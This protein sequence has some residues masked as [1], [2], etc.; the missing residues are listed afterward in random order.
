[1]VL[2]VV[3]RECLTL[4]FKTFTK[5]HNYFCRAILNV[6]LCVVYMLTKPPPIELIRLCGICFVCIAL[7]KFCNL[8]MQYIHMAKPYKIEIGRI[9]FLVSAGEEQGT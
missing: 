1:M 5:S 6:A 8:L 7:Q 2:S 4:G 9:R 3:K